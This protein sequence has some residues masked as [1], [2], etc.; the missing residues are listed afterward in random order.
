MLDHCLCV[1]AALSSLCTEPTTAHHTVRSPHTTQSAHLP[2][3]D[4]IP[5]STCILLASICSNVATTILSLTP[6]FN[7]YNAIAVMNYTAM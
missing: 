3:P 1:A 5:E 4:I 6:V 2:P 7:L